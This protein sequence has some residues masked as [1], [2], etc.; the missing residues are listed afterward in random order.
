[1]RGPAV[2]V[3]FR[4]AG[5]ADALCISVLGTQ[6]FLDTYA[7]DGIRPSLAR[8]VAGHLSVPAVAA[9]LATPGVS[10]LVAE[11]AGHLI[12]FAQLTAGATHGLVAARPAAELNRLYVLERFTGLGVGTALLAQAEALAAA[13]GAAVLWLTAWDGNRRALGFY[14]RRGYADVG[15]TP[16]VFEDER[17][18]NRV[19]A[20]ALAGGDVSRR[21]PA[22]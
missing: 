12:G 21:A 14:A 7:A 8:E 5:V 15:A 3:S 22:G 13:S 2:G 4:A 18:V 9:S 17:Y 20:K 10:F 11:R 1:M 6:V 19:F 16:Y